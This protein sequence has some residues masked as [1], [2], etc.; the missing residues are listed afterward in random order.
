MDFLINIFVLNTA[1]VLAIQYSAGILNVFFGV[2]TAYTRKI[3][4]ITAFSL[5]FILDALVGELQEEGI[6]A[7]VALGW[8]LWTTQF[9]CML[10]TIPSRKAFNFCLGN[11]RDKGTSLLNYRKKTECS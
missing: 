1:I 6:N 5:P 4:H 7:Q 9:T 10:F 2:K 11:I 8:N 3:I